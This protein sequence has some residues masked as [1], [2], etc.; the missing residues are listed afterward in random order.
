MNGKMCLDSIRFDFESIS[1][2]IRFYLFDFGSDSYRFDLISIRFDWQVVDF[3]FDSIQFW[4]G[5]GPACAQ[6]HLGPGP[7]SQECVAKI[8]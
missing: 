1:I 6:A 5:P 3:E 8:C 4:L 2:P 7:G